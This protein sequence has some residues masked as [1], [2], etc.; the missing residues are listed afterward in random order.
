MDCIY[1]KTDLKTKCKFRG[2]DRFG[3]SLPLSDGHCPIQWAENKIA[4]DIYD[5]CI[6]LAIE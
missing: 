1:D 3:S 4:L 6:G 5:K 2:L